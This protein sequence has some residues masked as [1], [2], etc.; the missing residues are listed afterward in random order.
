[1]AS[2]FRLSSTFEQKTLQ[3]HSARASSKLAIVIGGLQTLTPPMASSNWENLDGSL[4]ATLI[5]RRIAFVL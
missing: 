4:L 3:Q 1:M 2:F 5:S